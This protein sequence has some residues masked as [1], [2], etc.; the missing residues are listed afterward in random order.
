MKKTTQNKQ[1]SHWSTLALA[2]PLSLLIHL[3]S[4]AQGGEVSEKALEYYDQGM[5][6]LEQNAIEKAQLFFEQA[7]M[8]DPDFF[9]AYT[10]LSY[11]NT[12][13]GR[14][15]LAEYHARKAIDLKPGSAKAHLDL[16]QVLRGKKKA[17]EAKKHIAQAAALD[18]EQVSRIGSRLITEFNSIPDAIYYFEITYQVAP[19][20]MLNCLNY[21][22][23]LRL[24]G[25]LKE[26][27]T[28]LATGYDQIDRSNQ[29]F[30]TAYA[31]YFKLKMMQKKYDDVIN[32]ASEKVNVTY[33]E[34]YLY[35]AL[36]YYL[37]GDISQFETNSK[38][39]FEYSRQSPPDSLIDWA[40]S[41]VNTLLEVRRHS[42]KAR[43]SK[44]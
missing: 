14:Y 3:T 32:T 23:A 4:F 37:M 7:I 44:M 42:K 16:A 6:L 2:I 41:R 28:V 24:N 40:R 33:D 38:L 22:Y 43:D 9:D 11:I 31:L 21:S 34:Q 17:A 8:N 20:N 19:H 35:R 39:Y 13:L 36:S 30:E 12:T 25:Q 15:D 5:T 18:P 27:E 29:Y 10:K 1:R 26:A